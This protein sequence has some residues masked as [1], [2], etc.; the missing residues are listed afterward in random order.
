MTA[1][2]LCGLV[3]ISGCASFGA[4]L[5]SAERRNYNEALQATNDEQLL[6]N[7]VR[8]RYP[9]STAFMEVG[10][11]TAFVSFGY[12]GRGFKQRPAQAFNL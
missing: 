8:L 10:S 2:W 1:L 7:L 9:D 5:L 12:S 6:L 4:S 3:S 11:I